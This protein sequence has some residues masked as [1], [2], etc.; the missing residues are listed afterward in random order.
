MYSETRFASGGCV[1]SG[2]LP[3]WLGVTCHGTGRD[4]PLA[5]RHSGLRGGPAVTSS[6]RL[7]VVRAPTVTA[8]VRRRAGPAVPR[9]RIDARRAPVQLRS[10]ARPGRGTSEGGQ[11][12][13]SLSGAIWVLRVRKPIEGAK[14]AL[15]PRGFRVL[16]CQSSGLPHDS[17]TR[18]PRREHP[19][20]WTSCLPSKV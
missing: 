2:G 17:H 9:R 13:G 19:G 7:A 1:S 18:C 5:A 6:R 8:R 20:L 11:S 4:W 14:H 12:M 10:F 3:T 16:A 15:S